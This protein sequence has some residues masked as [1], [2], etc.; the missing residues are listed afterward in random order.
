M[1][2]APVAWLVIALAGAVQ[3]ALVTWVA[4]LCGG[5]TATAFWVCLFVLA[6]ELWHK[7][8]TLKKL[9]ILQ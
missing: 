8:R 1:K 2:V 5:D 4:G 3:I 6:T 9:G 7:Y